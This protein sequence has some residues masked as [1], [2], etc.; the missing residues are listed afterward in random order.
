[1]IRSAIRLAIFNQRNQ[2]IM[3]NSQKAKTLP[4]PPPLLR[5]AQFG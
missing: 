5:K 1:M 3:Q 2:A 4:D